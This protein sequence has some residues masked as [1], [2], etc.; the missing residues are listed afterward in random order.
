MLLYLIVWAVTEALESFGECICVTDWSAFASCPSY[1]KG[2][3]TWFKFSL[4]YLL[5]SK[6]VSCSYKQAWIVPAKEG[7][8]KAI[9]QRFSTFRMLWSFNTVS[10]V[11]MTPNHKCTS[12]IH[13]NFI[14]DTAMS[15][16]VNNWYPGYLLCSP[17]RSHNLQIEK[18]CFG[19]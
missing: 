11:V 7:W 16:S 18:H 13:C 9:E 8:E 4:A 3:F 14:F 12:L 10:H 6:G 2:N 19:I 17:Q 1:D 5:R 15:C